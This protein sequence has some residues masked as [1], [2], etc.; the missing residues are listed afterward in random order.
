MREVSVVWHGKALPG[1]RRYEVSD[2]PGI[3]DVFFFWKT[4]VLL[5]EHTHARKPQLPG[6]FSEAFTCFVCGLVHKEGTGPDAFRVNDAGDVEAAIEIKGTITEAGFTDVKRDLAFDEL[7]WLSMSSYNDLRFS[8]YRFTRSEVKTVVDKSKTRRDRGTVGLRGL[9]TELD[10]K[11]EVTGR[12]GFIVGADAPEL[13]TNVS[14]DGRGAQ[15]DRTGEGIR[16]GE[17]IECHSPVN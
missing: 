9:A 7:Y 5:A 11:P 10:R 14:G 15:E 17:T 8:I 1:C 16:P 3:L 4:T 12:I 6:G 13:L 2:E